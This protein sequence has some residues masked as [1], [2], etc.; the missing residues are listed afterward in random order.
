MKKKKLR[1]TKNHSS[2]LSTEVADAAYAYL[3]AGL[4]FIPIS[5]AS[6]KQ[7]ALEL[8][9]KWCEEREKTVTSW[10]MYS[11]RIPTEL[12]VYQW[13]VK[14]AGYFASYGI[15]IVA[16]KVS[17][18]L[19]ILDLDHETL[20][21]PFKEEVERQMP[22]L[23]D[24]LVAIR[25]P[26]PGLHLYYR[27]E[28]ISGNQKLA[29]IQDST[30][31]AAK[32]KTIIETRGEGGYCLAPPS[33]A[34]CHPS[35]QCYQHESDHDLTRIP[36]ITPEERQ[37][38]FDAAKTFDTWRPATP[39]LQ[40]LK[41]SQYSRKASLKS[42][43]SAIRPGD[44]FNQRANWADILTPHG[45]VYAGIG[46][47]G[48]DRWT[49]PGKGEGCS[50][51]TNYEGSD[52]LYVFSTNADPFESETTYDKFAALACLKFDGD[53]HLTS[54]YLR[55]QGYGSPSRRRKQKPA[56]KRF[57]SQH[58]RQGGDHA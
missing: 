57:R 49:R 27:C 2:V 12:E 37:I 3:A 17:G 6:P 32:P 34:S 35:E 18:N 48:A 51:T 20:I 53:F 19:E 24:R 58:I 5:T 25:T 56:R 21:E 36:T 11:Q 33:P 9:S 40:R 28:T 39:L 23:F 43:T 54:Q 55:G 22:G 8:L 7:P 38:L 16:G 26:R 29:R 30:S 4:S 45:W 42:H 1:P 10:K 14:N 52:L 46:A 31:L 47:D 13:Y 41:P 44:D 15:A 50:A